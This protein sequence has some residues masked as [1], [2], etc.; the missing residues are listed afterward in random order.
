VVRRTSH[1][2]AAASR[3]G[4]T[5]RMTPATRAAGCRVYVAGRV[6]ATGHG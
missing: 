6:G 1:Y 5:V 2:T 3:R 4:A